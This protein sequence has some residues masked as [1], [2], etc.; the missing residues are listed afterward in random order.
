MMELSDLRPAK[1][2]RR[3]GKRLG[4]GKGSGTGE[5]SGRGVKGQKARTGGTVRPGFEGGQMPLYRR[6]PKGGF[7]SRK[8]VRGENLY[9]VIKVSVLNRFEEGA[10]VSYDTLK[11]A[12]VTVRRRCQKGI[13]ILAGG[14]LE[15]KKLSVKVNAISQ[16]ARE[17]I[18][19][20]GG[21]VELT[22]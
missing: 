13:K 8:N 21:T 10:E 14:E 19:K 2:S 16:S 3:V 7:R 5:T 1:G 17:A 18:E 22:K 20:L 6:L 9:N 4:R 12:G 11:T 15:R